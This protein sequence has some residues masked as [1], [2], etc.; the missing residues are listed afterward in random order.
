MSGLQILNSMFGYNT[1]IPDAPVT[2]QHRIGVYSS[3]CKRTNKDEER[4]AQQ[5]VRPIKDPNKLKDSEK[6]IL[7]IVN[8]N[9]GITGVDVAKKTKWTQNHCSIILSTLHKK[10]L[11]RRVKRTGPHIRFYEYFKND[12]A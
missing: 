12:P 6:R 3:G 10:G 5:K 7:M 2:R 9:K 4:A 1:P 11:I 8:C